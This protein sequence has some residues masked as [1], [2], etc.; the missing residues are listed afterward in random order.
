MD[1]CRFAP[2][3]ADRRSKTLPTVSDQFTSLLENLDAL[4]SAIQGVVESRT[5]S[6]STGSPETRADNGS[7]GR[8][9]EQDVLDASFEKEV[10]GLFAL[11]AHEWLAQIHSALKRLS[12]GSSGTTRSKLSALCCR[13]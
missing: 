13:D 1:G 4:A 10:I 3:L 11:E 8:S 7:I 5:S 12:E 2:T 9:T 6:A